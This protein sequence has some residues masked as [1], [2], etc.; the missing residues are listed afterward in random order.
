[1]NPTIRIHNLPAA[2]LAALVATTIPVRAATLMW[3]HNADG[4]ASDGIGTWLDANQWVDSVPN[5]ATWNNTTP[6]NAVI[7]SGGAGDTITLGT[8]TAG[9][10]LLDNFTGTYTLSGLGL[11]QSGGVTIGATAGDV[12]ISTPVSGSGALVK[13]NSGILTLSAANS[14]SGG[15]TVNAG[16][17]VASA[18]TNLGATSGGLTFN[19]TCTFGNDGNWTIDAGRTITISDGANVTF[20]STFLRFNGPVVGSGTL[21]V[22]KPSQGNP[23]LYLASTDNTFTG[24]MNLSDKGSNGNGLYYF[25]SLGDGPGAGI[26]KLGYSPTGATTGIQ[27]SVFRWTTAAIAPLVLNHRQFDIGGTVSYLVNDNLTSSN[28]ITINTD[29]LFTGAGS[30]TLGLSGNNT[31]DN[32]IAGIIPNGPTGTVISL[33]KSGVGKWIL[34]G[35]NTYTGNTTVSNGTLVL[36]S[37]GQLKFVV[38][39]DTATNNKL[40]RTG[41]S[42]TLNGSFDI[43]TSATTGAAVGPWTLVSGSSVT[44]GGTFSVVG[45]THAGGGVWFRVIGSQ[46]WIFNQTTG[47]ISLA[48]PAEIL[49]FGI[50]G[51]TGVIDNTA[52]TID[53][54]VPWTPWGTIGLSTLAPTFFLS[55]GTCDQT[56]GSPPSPTFEAASPVHYVVTDGA[57]SNDY[58]VTVTGTPASTETVMSGF[59]FPGY[60]YAWASDATHFQM[61]VPAAASV[62]ALAPTFSISPFAVVDTP[63]GTASD[64]TNPQTYTLTAED[65]SQTTYTVTVQKS[66]NPGTGTYQQ[67]VLASGPVSYWPLNETSG[68]TAFDIASG[69]NNITYG[70]DLGI[71]PDNY[72]IN[73]PGLRADGNSCAQLISPTGDPGIGVSTQAPYHASLN[74]LRFSVECWVKPTST[75]GQYLVSLQDRTAGG[76]I[77]YTLWKNNGSAGFGVMAGIGTAST[78]VAVNGATVAAVGGVYHVVGTYDGTTLKLYV[79]GNLE[80]SA[81]LTYVPATVN[82]PGFSLGS[83][84]GSTA[85]P[86]YIQDVALYTRALTQAEI[87]NHYLSSGYGTWSGGAAFGDDTNGDG[88]A[89]GLAFLLGAADKDANALGRLPAP[90]NDSG[91][92]LMTFDCLAA[93]ARG[94]A[95]LNVQFS[96]DL[97]AADPWTGHEVAVPGTIGSFPDTG[98]GVSFEVSANGELL[99]VVATVAASKASADGKLFGRLKGAEN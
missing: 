27:G 60:G 30:R 37:T 24:P 55:S 82:Q 8:V 65:G 21:T 66:T 94:S 18:D 48:P 28:T 75:T 42:V 76:R 79:N 29:L 9:T 78:G 50:P 46:A 77:G 52:K 39:D 12:T 15:I 51:S 97:G 4:T 92:L 98:G 59:Y 73:Q 57:T 33:A 80:G 61:V 7:G 10:V 2:L 35:A 93:A 85:D 43:D 72:L 26:I 11:A 36:A 25:N 40:T 68:T 88:V 41:G 17:L 58:A 47:Q 31:G 96:N 19:G 56:S 38:T 45:F 49:G 5:P 63:S 91:K 13:N 1:M 53:L 14:F 54:T 74:P 62:T 95:V 34:S 81:N 32:T 22:A 67:K 83:R 69:I 6:D 44:Y 16:W 86:S 99:H 90:V 87:K 89:N 71:S 64:F 20:N 23:A 84:N 3:D 70:G